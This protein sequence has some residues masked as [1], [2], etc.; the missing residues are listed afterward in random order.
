MDDIYMQDCPK[1]KKYGRLVAIT[2]TLALLCTIPHF[3]DN[4]KNHGL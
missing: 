3:K 1:K 4:P 2:P